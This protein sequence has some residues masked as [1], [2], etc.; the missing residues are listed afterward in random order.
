MEL[1]VIAG[2]VALVCITVGLFAARRRHTP[3]F[4][5]ILAQGSMLVVDAGNVIINEPL[6]RVPGLLD[7]PE[8]YVTVEFDPNEPSVP[9]C[10]GSESDELDWELAFKHRHDAE[11]GDCIDDLHLKITWQVST[12]RTINWRLTQPARKKVC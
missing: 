3:P 8:R 1:T 12:A 2:L 7:D 11:T 10:A 9:P 4:P 6:P 5:Q